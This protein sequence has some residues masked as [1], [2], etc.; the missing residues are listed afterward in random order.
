VSEPPLERGELVGTEATVV[1]RSGML[2]A[3]RRRGRRRRALLLVVVF[4]L[5]PL[6]ALGGVG[7]WWNHELKGSGAGAAV[8][9]QVKPGWS[10]HRIA[11]ELQRDGVIG[12]SFVF[13]VYARLG[14]HR[15]FEAGG[16][17][18][19][20]G[21]GVER[22]TKILEARPARPYEAPQRTL[23]IVPGLWLSEV[24]AQVHAQLGLDAATF[25]RLVRTG[26]L[27]SR[28]LPPGVHSLE[29][30]LYPDTYRIAAGA[31]ELDVIRAMLNRFDQVVATL[32]LDAAA[33]RLHLRPYDLVIVASLVQSEAK[34]DVDRPLIASVVYNRLA[35][36]MPLQIDATLLYAI[37]R[38]TEVITD[39]TRNVDSPYNT[40]LRAGLPPTPISTV[41]LASLRAAAQPA[42]TTYRYYVLSDASGKHAFATT[43]AQFQQLVDAARA[44]GLLH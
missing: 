6:L 31:S 30:L 13:Q 18:L 25:I 27:A 19:H 23:R 24:A 34:L 10:V 37:G 12:S 44:K 43:S 42:T 39:A 29:G 14:N 8:Q 2:M 16:Y 32:G 26:A 11:D 7:L 40:Y 15:R 36:G 20:R 41:V 17:D 22:A 21:L 28:Y 35:L 38:H 33:A 5:V 3:R 9:F 1:G 4:M